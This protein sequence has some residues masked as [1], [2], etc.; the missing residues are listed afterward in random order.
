[1]MNKD[2][3]LFVIRRVSEQIAFD[4]LIYKVVLTCLL[5]ACSML[6]N[7]VGSA[8]KSLDSTNTIH[9]DG[10]VT[11]KISNI[12]ICCKIISCIIVE[13]LTPLRRPGEYLPTTYEYFVEII[14]MLDTYIWKMWKVILYAWR[15]CLIRPF[16]VLQGHKTLPH[17]AKFRY[18][19]ERLEEGN[20][21][22]L[23]IYRDHLLRIRYSLCGYPLAQAPSFEAVSYTWGNSSKTEEI[24]VDSKP[25]RTT[26]TVANILR[27]RGEELLKLR[28]S[29]AV[30]LWLD[31]LCI[32]QEDT[33]EKNHQVPL[34]RDI[35][36]RAVHV[37]IYLE[38]SYDASKANK[39]LNNLFHLVRLHS[40]EEFRE[41][42]SS[43]GSNEGWL[44]LRRMYSQ[45]FFN[46]IW[47]VQEVA[48][49]QNV[50]VIHGP[51]TLS[52][53]LVAWG[54][55][56]LSNYEMAASLSSLKKYDSPLL[57]H[58]GG[59]ISHIRTVVQER[60]GLPI[61]D[62]ITL[63]A[64]FCATDPRDKIFALLGLVTDNLDLRAWIDYTKPT[65]EVYLQ[66]TRY[67]LS[68]ATN[69]LRVLNFAGIGYTRDLE[70]LP[71]WVPE[72][73]WNSRPPTLS[74]NTLAF[75]E[76][77]ASGPYP[78]KIIFDPCPNVIRMNGRCVDSV[79]ILSSSTFA[80]VMVNE[81]LHTSPLFLLWYQE[82]WSIA[83]KWSPD[84]YLTFQ[85][86]DEAFWRTLLGDRTT[87]SRPA[88][89]IYGEYYRC[90]Q[91]VLLPRSEGEEGLN[92]SM[93]TR[94]KSLQYF[95]ATFPIIMQRR[96]AVTKKG[97][98]GFVPPKTET[99]DLVCIFAGANTPFL[100]R[101][102][103][104]DGEEKNKT[105]LLVGDCFFHGLMDGEKLS[106][107]NTEFITLC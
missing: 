84:P 42:Y 26:R 38:H 47:I 85:P 95:S 19:Y 9:D 89:D 45:P 20:I 14:H 100:I 64:Y 63:C 87:H 69:N 40:F 57:L 83:K 62:A 58:H 101:S 93:E 107:K 25:F 88:P 15:E 68:T 5:W 76:Y 106:L 18:S 91:E 92:L 39:L 6:F 7:I 27:K 10:E 71:S 36:R 4:Y 33:E 22:L 48:V 70:N 54:V 12:E 29:C 35:Y 53:D 97:Y 86:R 23:L 3:T 96:F 1:M 80:E 32:N 31:Y 104:W 102:Q 30:H 8:S 60:K 52:W 79:Q 94:T 72:W 2:L 75:P 50:L 74:Y 41:R 55:A 51:G 78:P 77:N 65:Q 13:K 82:C 66:T 99:G 56:L 44:A 43:Y 98:M 37:R 24:I 67:L 28:S 81:D 73:S 90:M 103:A 61:A 11:A 46:R 49:A 16:Y 34:M 105:H 21:R 17:E 59:I